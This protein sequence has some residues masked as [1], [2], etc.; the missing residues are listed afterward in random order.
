MLALSVG[1]N[2]PVKNGRGKKPFP[3]AY[4]YN[5]KKRIQCAGYIE[6]KASSRIN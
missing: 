5:P 3:L 1:E 2:Q 4:S 6:N